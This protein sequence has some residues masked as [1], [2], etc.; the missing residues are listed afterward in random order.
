VT[1]RLTSRISSGSGSIEWSTHIWEDFD[2]HA[3]LWAAL[4]R[5]GYIGEI[6]IDV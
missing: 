2:I 5:Q 1:K 4:S 6:I 3:E